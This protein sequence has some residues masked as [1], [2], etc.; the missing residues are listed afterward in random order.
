MPTR[1]RR[2]KE[3]AATAGTGQ[4]PFPAVGL[5]RQSDQ[6]VKQLF[7][8]HREAVERWRAIRRQRVGVRP[9]ACLN[10]L[11]KWL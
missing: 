9:V 2:T 3:K 10:R 11:V 6:V 4:Y 1:V 5:D 7:Q 8:H